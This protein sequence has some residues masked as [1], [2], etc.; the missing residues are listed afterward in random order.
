MIFEPSASDALVSGSSSSQPQSHGADSKTGEKFDLYICVSRFCCWCF[1]NEDLALDGEIDN[2]VH[3]KKSVRSRKGA[4]DYDYGTLQPTGRV[5]EG[6]KRKMEFDRAFI[7]AEHYSYG[8]LLLTAFKKKKGDHHQLPGGHVDEGDQSPAHA[9][10]REL[11]EETGIDIRNGL[12]R[13]S[14]V[15]INGKSS[16]K[17]RV[18]YY[19]PLNDDDR[20]GSCSPSSGEDFTVNL[21]SEHIGYCFEKNRDKAADLLY[22]HSGGKSKTA[23]LTFERI[24]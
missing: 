8:Y 16:L 10:A 1:E 4:A 9:A 24:K 6:I 14:Q 21:S 15:K 22:L 23:M 12:D 3:S 17:G 11:F 5:L 2:G 7:I 18:F 20:V 19:L 13:L